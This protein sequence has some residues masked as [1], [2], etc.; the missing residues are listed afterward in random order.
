MSAV[1]ER[2]AGAVIIADPDAAGISKLEQVLIGGDLAVEPQEG[3]GTR[4]SCVFPLDNH[5]GSGA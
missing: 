2:P 1:A 3:G 4:V 5:E